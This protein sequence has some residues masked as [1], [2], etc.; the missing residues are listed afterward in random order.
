VSTEIKPRKITAKEMQEEC[1]N[2]YVSPEKENSGLRA[3]LGEKNRN[4]GLLITNIS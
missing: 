3:Q 4:Y 2:V 1:K